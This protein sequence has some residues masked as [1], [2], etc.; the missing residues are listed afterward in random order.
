MTTLRVKRVRNFCPTTTTMT[1]L[2][3]PR[4]G[5]LDI[6]SHPLDPIIFLKSQK[7]IC[8]ALNDS[9]QDRPHAVSSYKA[10]QRG[11][12]STDGCAGKILGLVVEVC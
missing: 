10:T 1:Y 8:G 2:N 12:K 3:D 6:Y 4:K 11:A 5:L 7:E 9:I